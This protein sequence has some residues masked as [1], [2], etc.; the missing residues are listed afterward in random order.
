M[1]SIFT[2]FS[3]PE[4]VFSQTSEG[5]SSCL[6]NWYPI[7][8]SIV[9]MQRLRIYILSIQH[10]KALHAFF[11]KKLEVSNFWAQYPGKVFLSG[12]LS[13]VFVESKNG[14]IT[15]LYR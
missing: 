1:K 6:N 15:K 14:I 2:I 11:E 4:F 13:S 3:F 7:Y 9:I 8:S 12:L 10:G 5:I